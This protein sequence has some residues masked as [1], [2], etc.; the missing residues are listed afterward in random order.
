MIVKSLYFCY[1][2]SNLKVVDYDIKLKKKLSLR[3]KYKG[4]RDFYPREQFVQDYIFGVLEK[5]C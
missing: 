1:I 3:T 4:T 5:S 2:Y